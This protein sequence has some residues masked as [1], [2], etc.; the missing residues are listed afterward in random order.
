METTLN[1]GPHVH[2]V[3]PLLLFDCIIGCEVC[4]CFCCIISMLVH[5]LLV[6][7]WCLGFT[8]CHQYMLKLLDVGVGAV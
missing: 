7:W 2:H 6:G 4:I 3:N 8:L 5:M 1:E